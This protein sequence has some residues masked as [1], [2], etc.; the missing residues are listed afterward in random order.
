MKR[1]FA[2]LAAMLLIMS[3]C[4]TSSEPSPPP[5]ARPATATAGVP[6]APTTPPAATTAARPAASP[7]QSPQDQGAA[8]PTAPAANA[9]APLTL[10][11]VTVE[12]NAATRQG[13]FAQS[14][15]INLPPGFRIKIFAAGLPQ[16]RWLGL[17]PGGL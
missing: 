11:A 6:A 16:V 17:G 13:S 14:R 15:R 3:A 7:A 2:A 1:R 12:T 5:T 4:G 10:Q 9:D 8:P